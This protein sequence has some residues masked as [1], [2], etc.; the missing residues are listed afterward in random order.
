LDFWRLID[1]FAVGV[2]PFDLEAPVPLEV[3]R[4]RLTPLMMPKLVGA[5][6]PYL[7]VSLIDTRVE[8]SYEVMPAGGAP[9]HLELLTIVRPVFR[10]SLSGDGADTSRLHGWFGVGWTARIFGA[11]SLLVTAILIASWAIGKPM[12]IAAAAW[13]LPFGFIFLSLLTRQNGEDDIR[14]I[15]AN[16]E[17]ALLEG[18]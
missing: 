9:G 2:Q 5:G 18:D 8:A 10:G 14:L 4:Q 6:A 16:L 13:I 17:H 12:G 11:G 3:A 15:K 7:T 1:A